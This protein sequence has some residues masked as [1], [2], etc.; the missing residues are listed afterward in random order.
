MINLSTPSQQLIDELID[1]E[2]KALFWLQKQYHGEKGYDKMR[3]ELLHKCA[4]TH[5]QQVS[6]VVEYISPKGNRWM[7]FESAQ[8]YPD[9][10]MSHTTPIAFCY[11]ETYASVGAFMVGH[12]M[13]DIEGSMRFA[14][15]FT[16][17]FFLRFCQRLQ[18]PMRSRWM[19]QKFVE[20]IP[21]FAFSFGEK[22]EYGNIKVDCRLPGS[23]GRG[24]VRKDGKVIEIR[25]FL[26]DKQL[27]NKQLRDT[28]KVRKFG[29]QQ[30]YEPIEV[31]TQRLKKAQNFDEIA[32]EI[33]NASKMFKGEEET[34]V[35]AINILCF[36]TMAYVD[37]NYADSKDEAFWKRFGALRESSKVFDF[38][39]NYES[40]END[41]KARQLY[42]II[43]TYGKEMHIKKYEP[44]K[45]MDIVLDYWTKSVDE[46]EKRKDK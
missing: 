8:Y 7:I 4:A 42:D 12:N 46:L 30:R 31:R 38:A 2:K 16:D 44:Q 3:E 28:K 13:Y 6:D 19:I 36:M 40:M 14:I 10:G 9:A 34:F 15:I 24:V 11:Y 21:G 29:D 35:A 1:E 27:D 5:K 20:A 18:V 23:V 25:T 45:V 17:H 37:L 33:T 41:E 43:Q 39:K 22:N 32:K 26:T